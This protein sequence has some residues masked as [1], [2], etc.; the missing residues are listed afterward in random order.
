MLV[1]P[2]STIA[3]P[4][5]AWAAMSSPTARAG[6]SRTWSCGSLIAAGELFASLHRG[7]DRGHEFGSHPCLLELPDRA[8]RRPARR[9]DHLAQ[10]DRVDVLVAQELRGA[11][12]RLDDEPRPGLPRLAVQDARLAHRRRAPRV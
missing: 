7:I 10:L 8:D 12:H 4:S 9:G 2:V 3:P 11:E 6:S 5:A 1:P